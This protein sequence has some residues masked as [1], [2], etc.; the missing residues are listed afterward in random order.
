MQAATPDRCWRLLDCVPGATGST[1]GGCLGGDEDR[2]LDPFP[3]HT[4]VHE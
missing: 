3:K 4:A 2:S 1:L